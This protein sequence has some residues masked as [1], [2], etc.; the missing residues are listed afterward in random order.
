M[1]N[2]IKDILGEKYSEAIAN[3]QRFKENINNRQFNKEHSSL[4]IFDELP[5]HIAIPNFKEVSI[6]LVTQ[7]YAELFM[8]HLTKDVSEISQE[9]HEIAKTDPMTIVEII[10]AEMEQEDPQKHLHALSI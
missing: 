9:H 7:N 2:Q 6:N 3:R 8:P 10:A 5:P 1:I 4:D